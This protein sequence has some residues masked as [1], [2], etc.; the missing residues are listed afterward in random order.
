MPLEGGEESLVAS[1]VVGPPAL[2]EEGIY[3]IAKPG[4]D[5][6]HSIR[7]LDFA[8]QETTLVAPIKHMQRQSGLAVSP[9]GKSILYAE[10]DPSGS[11]IMLI[12]NFR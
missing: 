2:V 11:D 8:T 3:F 9:D 7:F 5:G 1:G 4:P 12:E 10:R 6:L